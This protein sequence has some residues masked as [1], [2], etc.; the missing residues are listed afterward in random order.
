MNNHDYGKRSLH[1][2]ILNSRNHYL[3]RGYFHKMVPT[4]LSVNI[5]V[6][7][8]TSRLPVFSKSNYKGTTSITQIM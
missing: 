4:K 3:V 1:D 7:L 8:G 5:S 6:I 2:Y